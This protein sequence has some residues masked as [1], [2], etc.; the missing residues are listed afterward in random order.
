MVWKKVYILKSDLIT[1]GKVIGMKGYNNTE[2]SNSKAVGIL[3]DAIRDVY[4]TN[5]SRINFN[6]YSMH[7]TIE[8]LRMVDPD[9][10]YIKIYPGGEKILS[11]T[12][13]I[14]L[15]CPEP[16]S[17]IVGWLKEGWN[18]YH[19]ETIDIRT[20][21]EEGTFEDSLERR[22]SFD[23]WEY[24]RAIWVKQQQRIEMVTKYF[25]M[26]S[27]LVDLFKADY[28]ANELV[29]TGGCLQ[30]PQLDLGVNHPIVGQQAVVRY[31]DL[32]NNVISIYY[33]NE[34]MLLETNFL[35][36]LYGVLKEHDSEDVIN[37]SH[38]NDVIAALDNY[39]LNLMDEETLQRFL[40]EAVHRLA[41]NGEVLTDFVEAVKINYPVVVDKNV[42]IICRKRSDGLA[43]FLE[44]IKNDVSK[45]DVIPNHLL[46]LCG[47]IKT[48]IDEQSASETT[49]KE[50]IEDIGG[51]CSDILLTKPCNREQ[52]QIIRD[53]EKNDSVVVQ[54]PRG[55]GKTH[56]IANIIGHFLAEGKRIL[57]VS[58][59]TKA[60]EVIQ[61]QIE[62][63]IKNLCVP[64]LYGNTKKFDEAVDEIISQN[65]RYSAEELA[66]EIVRIKSKRDEKIRRINEARDKL[67][68]LRHKQI[69]DFLYDGKLYSLVDIGKFLADNSDLASVIPGP[70]KKDMPVMPVTQNELLNL[71]ADNS[72]ISAEEELELSL[73][74]PA[75]D[76]LISD[77]HIDDICNDRVTYNKQMALLRAGLDGD[78]DFDYADGAVKI[79]GC[80]I[81]AN[82]DLERVERLEK[83]ITEQP[84]LEPW[85][86]DVCLAEKKGSGFY[87][88][89]EYL[90]NAIDEYSRRYNAYIVK[91]L[92]TDI[93]IEGSFDLI[94][95]RRALKGCLGGN[96]KGKFGFFDKHMNNDVKLLTKV[97]RVNGLVIDRYEDC[98][99]ADEYCGLLQQEIDLRRVW[100]QMANETDINPIPENLDLGYIEQIGKNIRFA[101]TWANNSYKQLESECLEAGFTGIDFGIDDF[102]HNN[103]VF[104]EFYDKLLEKINSYI[105]MAKLMVM[106]KTIYKR[107]EP[108][109]DVLERVDISSSLLCK[110][111]A[112]AL[113]KYDSEAYKA[114][115]NKYKKVLQKK[116]LF[117]E[118]KRVFDN[119]EKYA[120]EWVE[121]IKQ[122]RGIYDATYLEVDFNKAWQWQQLYLILKD[123]YSESEDS[124]IASISEDCAELH[125][126]TVDLVCK[127]AWHANIKVCS[128]NAKIKTALN[129]SK[130]YNKKIGLGTG[131]NV[132]FYLKQAKRNMVDCQL[133]VPAWVMSVNDALQRFD[134][135][136]N[137]FDVMIIDEASQSSSNV[138]ALTYMADKIIIV[139]DDKQVTPSAVG[140]KKEEETSILAKHLKGIVDNYIKF[141]KD[142]SVYEVMSGVSISRM[143]VEHFRCMPAIIGYCNKHYYGNK[144]KPL[145][146][147]RNCAFDTHI[148]NWRIDGHRQEDINDDEAFNIVALIK[149]CIEQPEYKNKS[150]GVIPMLGSRQGDRIRTLLHEK[151]GSTAMDEHNILCGEPPVFQG[152]ERDV[153]FMSLVDDNDT[154]HTIRSGANRGT[155]DQR[156]NVAVSRA[157]DQLWVVNSLDYLRLSPEDIRYKLL[158]YVDNYDSYLE[159]LNGVERNSE[160]PF[161]NEVAGYL[162]SKGYNFKQQYTVGRY[163]LDI[164]VF[165]QGN[166][167]AVECDG[168]M[169]HSGN[170]I[171]RD[172]EREDILKRV[173][174]WNFIRI[175]GGEYYKDKE[176]ALNKLEVKL[177][178]C[179]FFPEVNIKNT[180]K[181]TNDDELIH[182][183]KFQAQELLAQWASNA[184]DA[185][186]IFNS[187]NGT[188]GTYFKQDIDCES[189]KQEDKKPI[190]ISL[191]D[192]DM[193]VNTIDNGVYPELSH[194]EASF[195]TKRKNITP[196]GSLTEKE[197][198][199]YI[200]EHKLEYFDMRKK[201]GALWIVGGHKLGEILGKCSDLNFVYKKGGGR[202]TG[203]RDA[204]WGK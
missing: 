86:I 147:V 140:T 186:D 89:W 154:I 60:L 64:L 202:L 59:K 54:G 196:R 35:N 143:L 42:V 121:A 168:E 166:R 15:P 80:T 100:L 179:G 44:K 152:D 176:Q 157:K 148:I 155:Y 142:T 158:D 102:A 119:L 82:I 6:E 103:N 98:A 70:V 57:V 94:E 66:R 131:K 79:D 14:S 139:G 46:A 21:H 36:R 62:G 144:I 7:I 145:R 122:R 135:I 151:I 2:L 108:C 163:R 162:L 92:T 109:V 51:N 128:V 125:N 126:L 41:P 17:N 5:N 65:S 172:M 198:I 114:R 174:G 19:N 74:L 20:E 84:V 90:A 116:D 200:K 160:S 113:R 164:V 191:Q 18:N 26:L 96:K 11:I 50:K 136:E 85:L 187:N 146:D 192:E 3:F 72:K 43:S 22:N 53:I 1:K 134:P 52:L 112:E 93:T 27:D 201:G 180:V 28:D 55:T 69:A 185:W 175:R 165:Y 137:H 170:N 181:S 99:V 115:L 31:D 30:L 106:G 149:A 87:N 61:D 105:T 16:P 56:T 97:I 141:S 182:R 75:L 45:K 204:W 9:G 68:H 111:L 203:G 104:K 23:I 91:K 110:E 178:E 47:R 129:D 195:G 169:Y 29:L 40:Q 81:I 10:L 171:I 76:E 77:K 120:P 8:E 25:N 189:K 183:I 34:P 199:A 95:L 184:G 124:L 193:K 150:I 32:V 153:I 138:L 161:E 48:I 33:A 71:L 167:I 24:E 159:Q 118:R 194:R 177:A 156:Y 197:L 78:I 117:L 123:I 49:D 58:E 173:G 127:K 101:L 12:K 37:N 88:R 73:P 67:Y 132:Q 63:K 13:P 107:I 133:A 83:F 39:D 190:A 188:E 4:V 38:V 130:I